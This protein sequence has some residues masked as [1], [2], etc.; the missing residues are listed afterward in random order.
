MAARKRASA[1]QSVK[2]PSPKE[3]DK[4][5][6]SKY[7]VTDDPPIAPPKS[8]FIFKLIL[9]FS[10]PY[11]YLIFYHYKIDLEL[12][13]SIIINAGL[14]LVGFF[15]TL[16][17]IPVASR[18]VIRRNLFG[19]DINKRGTP[20]GAVKVPESLGIVVG[21]SFLVLAIVFQY[22]NFTSDSNWL[23][24]YNAALASI[25]FMTLLGFVDDVLD[26]P[27]RVKLL[28]P[29]FA[30]L[31]LLM[32]YAGHTTIII[33]KPLIPYLGMDVLDLGWIYKLYMGL[34]AVFCT[35][36]INIHA[37]LNG[38]EVGQTVVIAFAIL[39]HNVMQIGAST[40]PEYKQAHAFSIYLVQPL[41]ATSLGLL[42][43]N[44]Y[45]SSVFV[46]DTY[47]YFA[48][49]TMAVVG[50]L[51]HFSET[52]LIFFFPQVLN[53]LL[54]LPQLFGFIACPRHRLPRFDPQTGLLTGTNDGTL[55]NFFLRIFGR[56]TEKSL[57]TYLL[58]FQGVFCCFCFLLR[59]LLAG[60]YK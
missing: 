56:K 50:I 41:L 20:Q 26:V 11:L 60:W 53:F 4:T 54:S 51:G 25:C 16:R 36:S 6:Q 40:D 7:P 37:G 24:E 30:A 32:A 57:C 1:P 17:M 43:Y 52:L 10:I 29:S 22:F 3:I 47:T 45:P 15:V 13:R 12:R 55:V 5:R 23:V 39:V 59:Y 38:L 31:P 8:G 21:I 44:W 34:L 2:E 18:Y 27:W 35:N 42:A 9:F 28:L 48:G 33:P 58:V 46:G 49:M 19:Y 14:S